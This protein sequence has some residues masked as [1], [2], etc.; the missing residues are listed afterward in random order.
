M[1]SDRE[2]IGMKKCEILGK[3]HKNLSFY[4]SLYFEGS[5]SA[6]EP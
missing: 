1:G 5:P 4:F 6:E 2:G 3:R